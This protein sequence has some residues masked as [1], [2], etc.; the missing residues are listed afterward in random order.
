MA[1]MA[2][3]SSMGSNGARRSLHRA[4]SRTA[5]REDPAWLHVDSSRLPESPRTQVTDKPGGL[6]QMAF[7]ARLS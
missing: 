3:L 7:D 1:I 2:P 4:M 6:S 5:S